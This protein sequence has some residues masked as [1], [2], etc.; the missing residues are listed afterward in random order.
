LIDE[1]RLIANAVKHAE[2]S[3]TRQLRNIRPELFS[4]PDFAEIYEEFEEHGVERTLGA[5]FSPL[6]GEEFFVSEKLLQMYAETTESFF[7]EIADHFA[8]HRD[9]P[10]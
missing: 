2:G 8:A 1:L 4:N 6:S 3:A 9:D 5:V 7:G 10:Y